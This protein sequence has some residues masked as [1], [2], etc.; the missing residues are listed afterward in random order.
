MYSVV[1]M[2]ALSGGADVPASNQTA[3]EPVAKYGDHS[4]KQYRHGCHGCCGGWGG[5]CGGWGGCYGGRGGCCGGWGGCYGCYGGGGG[6]ARCGGGWSCC[7]GGGCYGYGGYGYGSP[8]ASG[9]YS[10]YGYGMPS[11]YGSMT[12]PYNNNYGAAGYAYGVPGDSRYYDNQNANARGLQQ[13]EAPATI[14][15]RLPAD[16]S[17]TIEGSPTTST[18][19]VRTFISPPLQPGKEYQY[20]LRAEATRDG[21]KMQSK[22]EVTVRAGQQSDV[23]I[24]LTAE[25]GS[26]KE[27]D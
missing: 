8:Y 12:M 21:K 27:K 7:G 11:Y 5:C 25:G 23:T 20:T 2:M 18:T 24:D 17:L 3:V 14:V 15:V 9:Y 22:R 1:L 4:H 6:Y 13:G 19:A 26:S 16:A 10:S